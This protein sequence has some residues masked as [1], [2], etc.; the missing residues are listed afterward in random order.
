VAHLS[1]ASTQT[2]SQS[3]RASYSLDTLGVQEVVCAALGTATLDAAVHDLCCQ[4]L[5]HLWKAGKRDAAPIS[6]E[7][8]ILVLQAV[9]AHEAREVRQFYGCHAIAAAA[10]RADAARQLAEQGALAVVFASLAAHPS[11][12][13]VQEAGLLALS[14]LTVFHKP[15][16]ETAAAAH[17]GVLV[18]APAAKQR[19]G[20]GGSA[21]S[22]ARSAYLHPRQRKQL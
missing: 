1:T 15:C 10:A 16:A 17:I 7:V 6:A 20:A 4:T 9:Q 18:S 2:L 13:L 21:G 12:A 8:T 5:M 22:V 3:A 19:C 14:N 11:N